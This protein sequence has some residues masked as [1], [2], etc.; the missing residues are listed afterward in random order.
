MIAVAA[1]T[2]CVALV[3]VVVSVMSGFLD[4]V[5][6]SGRT[7]MGDVVIGNGISGIPYYATLIERLEEHPK[8]TAATPIVD[9]WGL[10]RMPY[11]DANV[12]QSETV[13]VWGI[14]PE[15]FAQVTEFK[16]SLQW[17]QIVSS[18]NS[19]QDAFTITK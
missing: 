2:L 19:V 14:E 3:I 13:Q 4:M 10:L 17:E 6:S 15:S 5:Q 8:I 9:G 7:L 12:K 1:V 11:P 16:N 18:D